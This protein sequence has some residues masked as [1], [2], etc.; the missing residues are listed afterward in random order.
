MLLSGRRPRQLR[1]LYPLTVG[2]VLTAGLGITAYFIFTVYQAKKEAMI[3][4][5]ETLAEIIQPADVQALSGSLNDTSN[6]AFIRLKNLLSSLRSANPDLRFIRLIGRQATTGTMFFYAD[7]EPFSAAD[8]SLPGDLYP[9]GTA[10]MAEV[11]NG[12]TETGFERSSDEWGDWYSAY[13]SVRATR[14]G[15]V[16][17]LV[18]LDT[19]RTDFLLDLVRSGTVPLLFTVILLAVIMATRYASERERRYLEEKDEF[20]TIASHEIRAPLTGLRWATENLLSQSKDQT[21]GRFDPETKKT[22]ETMHNDCIALINN[23]NNLLDLTSLDAPGQTRKREKAIILLPLVTEVARSLELTAASRGVT[24]ALDPSLSTNLKVRGDEEELHHLF[25]NILSN[26]VRYTAPH[27]E[28]R[29]KYARQSGWEAV[30]VTDRGPGLSTEEQ[31][32]I[33]GGFRGTRGLLRTNEHGTGIGLYLA[34]RIAELHGGLIGVAS[35]PGH[36][37]TFTVFLP[38]GR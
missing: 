22:I 26:A 4:R 23:L 10:L 33:F 20:I 16:V 31:A 8:Y 34:E 15:Q 1:W 21:D 7:S 36:G 9:E 29:V 14:G 3:S 28:V 37:S 25:A 6:P 27:T 24:I 13:A 11:L 38:P 12:A 5:A 32:Q 19:L 30:S 18:R 35:A 2:L 17:A